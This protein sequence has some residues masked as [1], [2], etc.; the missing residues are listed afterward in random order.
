MA[1]LNPDISTVVLERPIA[2]GSSFLWETA[3]VSI[4]STIYAMTERAMLLWGGPTV[5]ILGVHQ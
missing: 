1:D 5:D 3:G 4:R 2:A